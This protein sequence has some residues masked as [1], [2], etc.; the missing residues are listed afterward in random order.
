[1][2]HL[3]IPAE[4]DSTIE[5]SRPPRL[6]NTK[7]KYD[8]ATK[9]AMMKESIV[10]NSNQHMEHLW[11]GQAFCGYLSR[12]A[13]D[14][15]SWSCWHGETRFRLEAHHKEIKRIILINSI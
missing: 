5:K 8:F 3:L 11:E 15:M 4:D 6:A 7:N 12:G 9:N 2:R 14:R 13:G 1:M 10:V